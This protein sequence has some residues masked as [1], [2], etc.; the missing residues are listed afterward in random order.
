MPSDSEIE[1][2]TL[3]PHS[4]PLPQIRRAL[5]SCSFPPAT[6]PETSA[7][8]EYKAAE[9]RESLSDESLRPDTPEEKVWTDEGRKWLEFGE[10]VLKE[11]WSDARDYLHTSIH[12]KVS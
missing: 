5:S 8:R 9:V 4:D 12:P 11:V 1:T 10:A 2:S 7:G 3:V 6:P